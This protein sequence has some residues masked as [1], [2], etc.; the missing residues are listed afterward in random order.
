M[1]WLISGQLKIRLIPFGLPQQHVRFRLLGET[2]SRTGVMDSRGSILW[3]TY[4]RGCN[5]WE[6]GQVVLWTIRH[7]AD[8]NLTAATAYSYLL[9]WRTCP[10]DWRKEHIG[11]Y[12]SF[13]GWKR[14]PYLRMIERSDNTLRAAAAASSSPVRQRFFIRIFRKIHTCCWMDFKGWF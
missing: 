9:A 3:R 5:R 4:L 12:M 6:D 13:R 11:I 8:N 2:A 1:D 14:L 7:P 10:R